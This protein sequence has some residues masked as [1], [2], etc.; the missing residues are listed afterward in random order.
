[1]IKRPAAILVSLLAVAF[2]LLLT[3][4][5]TSNLIQQWLWMRQVGFLDIFWRLLSV[6]WSL[7]G[8]SFLAVF[9]YTWIN[10]RFAAGTATVFRR[11]GD[12]DTGSIYTRTGI[13]ISPGLLKWGGSV[14]AAVIG[15]I[16]TLNFYTK[17]DTYLR[18]RWGG[19]VG[20]LDPIFG[21]DIGFYL[22]Q[23]PFYELIQNGMMS[24]GLI[25]LIIVLL[26]Y[27]YLGVFSGPFR[28]SLLGNR[29]GVRRGVYGR[30]RQ[31]HYTLDH[32]ICF[33]FAGNCNCRGP[34]YPTL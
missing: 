12:G 22:F 25:S 6:K 33:H 7:A 27:S 1:M 4:L 16:Y 34:S 21:K 11:P 26:S 2:I 23:L 24:L 32:G 29:C 15:L 5:V 8:L 19:P 10:F 20:Q 18:F 17:W 31:P 9:F 13:A 3:F 14:I 30:Q 28:A